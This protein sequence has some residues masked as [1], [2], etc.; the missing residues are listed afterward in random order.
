MPEHPHGPSST[1]RGAAI[2][3]FPR[4]PQPAAPA[5]RVDA[6]AATLRQAVAELAR[7]C[8]ALTRSAE[9]LAVD[10]TG[11]LEARRRL[12]DEGRRAEAIA[13]HADRIAR[14]IAAGD[15][16]RLATLQAELAALASAH[17]APLDQDVGAVPTSARNCAP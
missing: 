13:A 8:A 15:L 2:I 14:A 10:R 1:P 6:L 11:F 5:R 9:A 3:A 17:A 16:A 7:Q 4:P 12:M